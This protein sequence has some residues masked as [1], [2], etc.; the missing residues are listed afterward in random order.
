MDR[1]PNTEDPH[2]DSEMGGGGVGE[3]G[4]GVQRL[5]DARGHYLNWVDAQ[6]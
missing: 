1:V 5:V 2:L 6:K 4:T 3:C